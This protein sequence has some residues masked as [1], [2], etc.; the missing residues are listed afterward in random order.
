MPLVQFCARDGPGNFCWQSL[1]SCY[2]GDALLLG[3]FVARDL[4][5]LGIM[6]RIRK[7]TQQFHSGG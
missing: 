2:G 5:R 1:T 7:A 6:W 3:S 4:E